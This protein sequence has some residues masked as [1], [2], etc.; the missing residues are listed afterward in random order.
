VRAADKCK[1]VTDGS[2]DLDRQIRSR[3]PRPG[4]GEGIHRCTSA[5]ASGNREPHSKQV[6]GKVRRLRC[7]FEGVGY[8][9]LYR[10]AK[11]GFIVLLHIFVKKTPKIPL[12]EI[13]IALSRWVDFEQRMNALERA[14]P[15][16]VGDD[17]P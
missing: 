4:A 13:D 14:P 11:A 9:I 7:D 17:A 12:P 5:E 8:R 3:S 2:H 1:E 15:R 6:R 16:A 10:E